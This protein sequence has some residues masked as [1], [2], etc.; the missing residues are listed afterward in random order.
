MKRAGE[1]EI[2]LR[3]DRLNE[4]GVVSFSLGGVKLQKEAPAGA[5]TAVFH[6]VR[7]TPG[8]G[9]LESYVTQDGQKIG[10]F[11]IVVKHLRK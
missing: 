3:F 9:V 1:Y 11:D 8:S 4:D 6:K 5:T 7:L 2:A 10:M